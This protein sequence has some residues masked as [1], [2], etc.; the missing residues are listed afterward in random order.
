VHFVQVFSVQLNY[1]HTVVD[2]LDIFASAGFSAGHEEIVPF[3]V[4]KG[5]L[6]VNK[7]SSTFDG[8]L[9]I[10]F[11]KV[12]YQLYYAVFKKLILT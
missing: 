6:R 9:H 10:E 8:T 1:E 5:E 4:R 11:V 7:E 3:S 12:V 2:R